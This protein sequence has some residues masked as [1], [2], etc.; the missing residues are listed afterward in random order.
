MTAAEKKAMKAYEQDLIK[1]G[2]EKEL[3][4]TMAKVSVEYGLIRPVVN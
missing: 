3:A 4:H 1:Q 2:I